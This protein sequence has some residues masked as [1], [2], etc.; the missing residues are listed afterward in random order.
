M[1]QL[2]NVHP[3][4]RIGTNVIIE[5]FAT[6]QADVEIGDGT[7]IGPGA[8]IMDGSRIGKNCKIF[9][10]AVIGG[11]P[12]DLKFQGEITTAEIGENTTIRECVTVNRGTKARLKTVIGSNCLLM[13][14]VHIGHDC[15]LG[16]YC[17]LANSV[18]LAGEVEV[19]DWAIV[20][21]M[22][23]VHQFVHIGKH[24]MISGMSKVAKDVPHYIK[25]GRDPL[26]YAGINSIGLKR[27]NFTSEK[28]EEIKEYYRYIYL[29]GYNRSAA[30]EVIEKEFP[31]TPERIEIV[32]FIRS[33]KR[34][35]IKG[36]SDQNQNDDLD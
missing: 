6:I 5:S 13:A 15:Q 7:W 10:G 4:A 8:V 3:N 27:R 12:Q 1:N 32:Q 2:V 9:P 22:S 17:I 23:G 24:V 36:F 30:L 31:E 20:G 29:K 25:A 28:V 11:I 21:A 35:I 33:S 26:S 16:N 34:G 19:G 18:G 14:Y